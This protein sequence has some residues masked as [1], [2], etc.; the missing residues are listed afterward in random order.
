VSGLSGL[1]QASLHLRLVGAL[2]TL[3]GLA[4]LVLPRA[5]GWA[6]EMRRLSLLNRQISYVHTFFIGLMCIQFGLLAALAGREL[7]T[8]AP[9]AQAVLG[10]S[11][12]FWGCR[13]AVQLF[14]FDP[15]LWRGRW[16][17]VLGHVAMLALWSYVTAVF[18]WSLVYPSPTALP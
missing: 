5:L 16:I 17:T 3:V 6:N 15:S 2:L 11:V 4:H 1:T 10:A 18:G 14:V 9:L 8:G 13:L 12:V 7:L